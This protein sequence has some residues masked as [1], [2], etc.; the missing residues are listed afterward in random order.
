M[1]LSGEAVSFAGP[2]APQWTVREGEAESARSTN[3][4]H[5]FTRMSTAEARNF[6]HNNSASS[7]TPDLCTA[8]EELKRL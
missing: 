3:C 1:S 5:L 2:A 6:L 7:L 8:F 4:V